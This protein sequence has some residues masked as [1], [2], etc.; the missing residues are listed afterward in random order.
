MDW[1]A[2][3][4]EGSRRLFLVSC[5]SQKKGHPAPAADLYVSAWFRKARGLVEATGSP[6]FILSAEHGLLPPHVVVAPYER[7]LNRMS[8][9]DRRA[10]ANRVREQIVA[11]APTSDEVVVLAGARYREHLLPWLRERFGKVTIPME[12]LPIGHQLNWMTHVAKL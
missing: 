5:V 1:G 8:A 9:A 3:P 7:T 12:G 6:W 10:W 11:M 4:P 2:K